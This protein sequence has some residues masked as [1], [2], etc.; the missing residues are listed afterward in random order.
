MNGQEQYP[1]RGMKG[2]QLGRKG[3]GKG[4]PDREAFSGAANE[5]GKEGRGAGGGRQGPALNSG[6]RGGWSRGLNQPGTSPAAWDEEPEMRSRSS[7][8]SPMTNRAPQASQRRPASSEGF[9]SNNTSPGSAMARSASAHHLSGGTAPTTSAGSSGGFGPREQPS[10]G[11]NDPLNSGDS[12]SSYSSDS[13]EEPSRPFGQKKPSGSAPASRPHGPVKSVPSRE[14][15]QQPGQQSSGMGSSS[16]MSPGSPAPGGTR[17]V[18][19]SLSPHQVERIDSRSSPSSQMNPSRMS[20][21]P[22]DMQRNVSPG[23]P[24][25][26]RT[27]LLQSSRDSAAALS[28][29]TRISSSKQDQSWSSPQWDHKLS[30]I[31]EERSESSASSRPSRSGRSGRAGDNEGYSNPSAPSMASMPGTPADV[32]VRQRLLEQQWAKKPS[33]ARTSLVVALQG[34]D[35]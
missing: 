32:N 35:R 1:A 12:E 7:H 25:P 24:P 13:S 10:R 3:G 15:R 19:L 26:K 34:R 22:Q 17:M 27:S 23:A 30:E 20:P 28:T 4:S 2:Q 8:D 21:S 16:S 14:P 9:R 11:S 29:A 6:G 31:Q 5:F 33:V 18:G